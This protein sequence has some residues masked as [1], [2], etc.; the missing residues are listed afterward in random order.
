MP[1]WSFA[2]TQV[3]VIELMPLGQTATT[4][5]GE[6]AFLFVGFSTTVCP[7]KLATPI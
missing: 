5:F 1:D 4:G 7:R 2:L 6:M 3:T